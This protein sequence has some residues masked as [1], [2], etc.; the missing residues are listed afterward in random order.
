MLMGLLLVQP[1]S[2]KMV[3]LRHLASYSLVSLWV[4]LSDLGASQSS[5]S[6]PSFHHRSFPHEHL[7][8]HIKAHCHPLQRFP[9]RRAGLS[10]VE[11]MRKTDTPLAV[12]LL[13]LELCDRGT[14]STEETFLSSPFMSSPVSCRRPL[15]CHQHHP[16]LTPKPHAQTKAQQITCTGRGS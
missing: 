11:P 12:S 3:L 7:F 2:N 6:I 16:P 1:T 8:K 9:R 4:T 14:I 10:N 13:R 15:S 5:P